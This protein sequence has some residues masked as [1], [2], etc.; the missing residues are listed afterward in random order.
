MA[1][2][3]NI[4]AKWLQGLQS[5]AT[6]R[7]WHPDI[8]VRHFQVCA[9]HTGSRIYYRVG[10][11]AGNMR[12]I[13][14][15]EWPAM[16]VKV[17]RDLCIEING[18]VAAGRE[19]RLTRRQT[20]KGRT[21]RDAWEWYLEFHAKP[22][23][24]T[25]K[26]DEAVWENDLKPWGSRLLEAITRADVVELVARVSV[27]HNEQG[28]PRG[29]GAGN[30]VIELIRGIYE[31]EIENDR[32]TKNPA[33]KLRKHRSQ[34]RERF[35]LPEEVPLFFT[36]LATFRERIQDFFLLCIFTGARRANVM[37]ARW[38]EMNLERGVWVI[39][40]DKAK[41]SKDKAKSIILPLASQAM[42]IL[43]RRLETQAR[44][45]LSEWVF[46]S[47][48]SKTGHY[49]EPKDA[50][51]RIIS[52]AGLSDITIHDLRRTLGSWQAGQGVSLP[53]IGKTLGHVSQASTVIYARLANEPVRIA[54]QNATDAI[55][56]ASSEKNS[57]ES[58]K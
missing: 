10:R 54:V 46:P 50:W 16:S 13:R 19:V 22:N 43:L 11:V 1:E 33:R 52:K 55:E 35:L 32:A 25:W 24:R 21:L 20:T 14:L 41:G 29:P 8:D 37:A 53:I 36:S 31:I 7:E 17:A 2:P 42:E 48:A 27:Q 51:R 34:A 5:P 47:P 57:E 4:S 40:R 38:D 56:K 58:S 9:T 39:P 45:G 3:V 6:G 18:D 28:K 26:R 12:R 44:S 23:K 15:G 30:K 49:V